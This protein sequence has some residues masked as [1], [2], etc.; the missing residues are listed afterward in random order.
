MIKKQ[1]KL[2]T[3]FSILFVIL[4]VLYFAVIRP[5]TAEL[6]EEY[7]RPDLLEGEAQ[8]DANVTNV[9]IF[10][11]IERAS[12][13]TIEVTNEYGGYKI[14]RDASDNFKLA[15][16]KNVTFNGELFASLVVTT[17]SPTAMMRVDTDP[18][19][20]KLAEYGLDKPQAKWKI[21]STDGTEHVVLVGDLLLT[22][23][24][25]YVQYE[26]RNVV[27]VVSATLADTI[28][29]PATALLNT[30]LISGPTSN[31]YYDIPDFTIWHGDEMYIRVNMLD[32]SE[33]K[34]E[35][36]IVEYKLV[37]PR[38]D[39]KLNP[40]SYYQI[41]DST[42]LSVGSSF[43][44]LAADYAVALSPTAE[45]L[46][47]FGL[48]D[49]AYKVEFK[50]Q[51]YNYGLYF[52]ELQEDLTH[53]VY[54]SMYGQSVIFKI[55]FANVLWLHYDTLEWISD[56][57]FYTYITD[58]ANIKIKGKDVDVD[59]QLTHGKDEIGDLTLDV[60]EKK[61]NTLIP[62]KEVDNFRQFYK[63]LLN[64]TTKQYA[65]ISI[66]DQ[67]ALM[68][69]DSKLL[70]TM[71]FT[72][73]DGKVTEY[74]YYRYYESST[75]TI[76]TGRIFVVVD[77]RGEFY[78]TNDLVEKVLNSVPRVLEGEDISAYGRN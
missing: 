76:T 28:L 15:E 22:E 75:D 77:G 58:I 9:Y 6:D 23:A 73:L 16:N 74:K 53:Y 26:G 20:E 34:N 43:T 38:P 1:K 52:S 17:G 14:Y 64:I 60:L 69:D 63:T 7:Q 18:T 27:Y 31:T 70:M 42:M 61:S 24:A 35:D 36:A 46:K 21:T 12:I 78:T 4:V 68:K 65:D 51:D 32:K 10:K 45:Q 54:S 25:Y 39:Q 67:E 2:I 33:M 72:D 56:T 40:G 29:Q 71:I 49:P 55:S 3:I 5:L 44:A 41:N 57:P 37:Y 47:E 13:Q 19:P 48:D 8:V 66:E 50:F 30:T 11:P 62:N 59:F